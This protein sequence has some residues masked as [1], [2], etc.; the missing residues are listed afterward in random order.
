[1]KKI[2]YIASALMATA[3]VGCS[4]MNTEPLG[5]TVT[6]DQKAEAA[7]SNP[8]RVEA[9]VNAIS[10]MFYDFGKNLDESYHNDL[11]YPFVMLATDCRGMDLVSDAIGYNWFS[12]AVD[13]SDLNY[14][15]TFTY[16]YWTTF[17]K[18]LNTVNNVAAL[19]DPATEDDQLM[20]YLA[21]A[22]AVR[23]FDYFYLAQ[24]YQQTYV[25]NENKPCVP[26]IT[27]ANMDVAATDGCKRASVEEIYTQI[28]KDLDAAIAM[29][30]KTTVKRADKRYVDAAVAYGIRARVNLVMNNWA[31]AAADAA[32]AI[33]LTE[34]TPYTAD[35]VKKPGMT[36]IEDNS[37]M[38]GMLVAETDRPVTSGICNWPSHMG[39][40]GY[41]YASVGA[42][43]KISVSLYDAIPA[44]DVR[45]GW[46]LDE[47]ASS[48]YLTAEQ[49]NYVAN[50]EI[51][52]YTHVKFGTYKDELGT[53]TNAN[54]IPLM[55][56][57]EMYLIEAEALA[58]AGDPANGAA[59]LQEFVTTYRDAAYT[60]TATEADRVQ[61]AVWMQRR[62]ELWGEGFSYFDIL[63]LNKGV[64]RRGTGFEAAYVYNIPAGDP[65]LIYRIP[66]TEIEGNPALSENDNNDA[67][68]EPEPVSE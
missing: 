5:S 15:G 66:K 38:W 49:V 60:C 24:M 7:A 21:Q 35:Q 32:K 68:S 40:F 25:G 64:D 12:S 22:L 8:A 13:Y 34:S 1:M 10:A 58:M 36:E 30:E 48:P 45:K 20:Y 4:D 61:N 18:Q 55:R 51:P 52:P 44:T 26:L 28:M 54:D 63:R 42:W 14:N 2:K 11:K 16:M 29:L 19:I 65:A 27:E 33:E 41:G 67:A 56:V 23:A 6:T 17:Y 39:T 62:I 50:N 57:E 43:R 59:K 53:S 47:N 46:F 3:I 31:E 37:W 9:S